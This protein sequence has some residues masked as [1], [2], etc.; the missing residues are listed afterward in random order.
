LAV[1]LFLIGATGIALQ[2]KLFNMEEWGK[3]STMG[4]SAI[5][6]IL[7]NI[8]GWATFTSEIKA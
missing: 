3:V 5:I 8:H 2:E 6:M 4:D 7:A 1:I